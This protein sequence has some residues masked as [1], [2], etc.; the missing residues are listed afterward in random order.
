M[1][2]FANN[3]K[4]KYKQIYIFFL[5][6]IISLNAFLVYTAKLDNIDQ[7]FNLLLSFGIYVYYKDQKILDN[8]INRF[9]N[10]LLSTIILLFTLYRSLWIFSGNDKF[11]YCVF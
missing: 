4:F 1:S 5:L 7:I 9:P 10:F 3:I 6:I 11:I 8:L 2:F